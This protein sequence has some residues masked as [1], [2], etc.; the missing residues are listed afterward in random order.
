MIVD[1]HTHILPHEISER[2]EQY[3]A[4][5]ATFGVLFAS[6]KARMATAEELI[7]AMDEDGVDR[8]VV[9]GFG[10]TDPGLAGAANDY[11]V[12][13]V[14]RFPDRLVGFGGVN[15]AWGKGAAAEAERCARAGLRGL[16]EMHPDSQGFELGDGEVMAPIAD[17]AREFGLMITTHSSEPVGHQ[18]P[19]KGKTRPEALWD[20]IE[21]FPDVKLI[22]AHWGG[23]LPFY[24][25]M[26]EIEDALRNVYFDTAASPFLYDARIFEVTASLV[27]ADRIL[28]GSDFPLLRPSRLLTQLNDSA[29]SAREKQAIS[30]ENAVRL[31]GL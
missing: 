26:P 12:D 3:L 18:Y 20:L 30:G 21:A 11:I 9:M 15:P 13:S 27:G 8:S 29:L 7:A 1:F 22:C 19:G 2:R 17:V 10:W 28:L 25:L 16:G 31:L 6:P 4:R 23:G 5:D 14:S 24:T